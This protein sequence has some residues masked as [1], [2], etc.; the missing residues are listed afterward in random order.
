MKKGIIEAS[1]LPN[2]EKIWM[3]K[4]MGEWKVVYP[5][6][7]EDGSI[8]WFNLITGGSWIKLLIVIVIVLMIIGVF[9][10]YTT[11]LNFCNQLIN[12][13]NNQTNIPIYLK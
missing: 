4:S 13:I 10:E 1:E 8:N 9:Y 6:T 2:N 12:N 5:I 11:N 3:K 7:N